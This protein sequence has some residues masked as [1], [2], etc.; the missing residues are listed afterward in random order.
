MGGSPSV[1]GRKAMENGVAGRTDPGYSG[2]ATGV[3]V[4]RLVVVPSPSMPP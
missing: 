4:G 1:N 3:G 2:A